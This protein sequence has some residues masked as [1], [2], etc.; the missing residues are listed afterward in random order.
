MVQLIQSFDLN[1]SQWIWVVLCALFIGM[2]KTGVSGLGMLVVPILASIFG[3]KLS[4][5][6]LLP[7]LSIADV[8]AVYY[9]HRHAEWHYVLKLMPA[10]AVGIFIG[11]YVGQI[12][13][14]AQF[15]A[16]IAVLT[17]AGLAIMIWM[18]RKGSSTMIPNNWVF[19]SMA[20]LIGGFSTM[21]GNAAGPVMTVYFLAMMLPKNGF[22]GTQAW[23]FLIVNLF[24][25]P[26]QILVWDNISLNTFLLDLSLLPVILLGAVLGIK[27]VKII[28][29]KPYRVFIIIS[30][31]LAALRL[32]F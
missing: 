19:A 32:F 7:M 3:G 25:M 22:I 14:D 1:T 27:I 8:F 28:P 2:A 24:K 6:I 31:A 5:G 26:F 21:I 13:D 30:T 12:I 15:K 9:Y 4:T 20:G 17:M 11:L 10:T 16:L 23:F 18:E 29:E